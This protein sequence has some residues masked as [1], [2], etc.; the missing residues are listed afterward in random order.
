MDVSKEIEKRVSSIEQIIYSY[1]PEEEGFEA[2]IYAAMSYSVKA[3]GKRLRPMLMQETLLAFG[4]MREE[5]Y[6]FMAAIEM[7]HTYSLVHD[8]LPA[9]DD[10]KLRRG[11][12]TTHVQYGEAMAILAGDGLLNYAFE[13]AM[14]AFDISDNPNIT[15]AMKLLGHYA[16]VYGMIGGQVVDIESENMQDVSKARL[17]YIYEK[18]TS[19]L[20]QASMGI[21]AAIGGASDKE[22]DIIIELARKVGL[23]FQIQDDIL[24]VTSDESV[25]GKDIG[26][27]EKNNKTTYVSLFGIDGAKEHVA[28]LTEE[29]ISEYR[30]L[31]KDN[32]FLEELLIY[33]VNR[34]K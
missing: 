13:T 12:P 11:K 17:D 22:L 33:L 27:D 8:D 24:D 10:D 7:I 1:L 28:R 23:A 18:K 25:L 2:N 6:P 5:I 21:G 34:E 3:G 4:D 9:M 32:D 20:L 14:K 29:A 31:E 26:S 16:G 15:K 19:A 30:S